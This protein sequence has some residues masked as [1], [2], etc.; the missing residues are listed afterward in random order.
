MTDLKLIDAEE[1]AVRLRIGRRTLWSLTNRNAIP[2]TRIG[3]VVRYDPRKL[4]KWLDAGAPTEP[5]A[6]ERLREKAVR[7]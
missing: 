3:R 1:A 2:H 7:R 5:G 6:A 4:D